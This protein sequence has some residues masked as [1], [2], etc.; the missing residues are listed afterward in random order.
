M[1]L[2]ALEENIATCVRDH[3]TSMDAYEAAHHALHFRDTE[4][5]HGQIPY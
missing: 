2:F 1:L 3:S 4:Q 5:Y